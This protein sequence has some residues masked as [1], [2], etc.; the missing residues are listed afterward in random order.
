MEL[1][2]LI[3]GFVN[4]SNWTILFKCCISLLW[5][6]PF[7]TV[8]Q[9][10]AFE[11]M[12]GLFHDD[13]GW[14]WINDRQQ[15]EKQE[16]MYSRNRVIGPFLYPSCTVAPCTNA[17]EY[18][19]QRANHTWH[20]NYEKCR[21]DNCI[22]WI[23]MGQKQAQDGQITDPVGAWNCLVSLRDNPPWHDGPTVLN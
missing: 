12:N 7:C 15:R 22:M 4:H 5:T 10:E 1:L 13:A 23:I 8:I 3:V 21:S 17:M 19:N 14:Q 6:Q 18:S 9:L 2:L 20:N 11:D 16:K